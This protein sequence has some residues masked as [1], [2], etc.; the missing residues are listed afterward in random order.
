[1]CWRL[2]GVC[3]AEG[4]WRRAEFVLCESCNYLTTHL[5]G[6]K[7]WRR[8]VPDGFIHRR[9]WIWNPPPEVKKTMSYEMEKPK[10]SYVPFESADQRAVFAWAVREVLEHGRLE[11]GLMYMIPEA[12]RR[13]FVLREILQN[14]QLQLAPNV[15]VPVPKGVYGALYLDLRPAKDKR[16]KPDERDLMMELF[17]ESGYAA[18][19]AYGTDEAIAFVQRYLDE[20]PLLDAQPSGGTADE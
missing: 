13:S 7:P 20:Q 8:P 12:A 5:P 2:W 16:R 3:E 6:G 4:Y 15:C 11:L 10:M 14:G 9:F 18:V 1:M 19:T 17:R